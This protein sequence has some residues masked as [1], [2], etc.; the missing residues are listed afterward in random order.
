MDDGRFGCGIC[1]KSFGKQPDAK[2]HYQNLH[3]IDRAIK[4]IRCRAPGCDKKFAV[5]KYMK[6]HMK[7]THGISAKMLKSLKSAKNA[8]M[9]KVK[10]EPTEQ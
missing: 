4:N 1:F 2:R 3:M 7:Q 8:P 5:E 6:A 10:Q 9:K